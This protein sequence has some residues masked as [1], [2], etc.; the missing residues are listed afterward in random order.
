MKASKRRDLLR[1]SIAQ[2]YPRVYHMLKAKG[3]SAFKALEILID[4][5]RAVRL[6]L[7]CI[8]LLR[9]QR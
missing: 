7:D 6:A 8:Q 9:H 5:R 1:Y 4:A 3:F 2:Q